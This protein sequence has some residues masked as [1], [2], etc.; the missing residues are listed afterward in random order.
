MSFENILLETAKQIGAEVVNNTLKTK[1]NTAV[2]AGKTTPVSIKNVTSENSKNTAVESQKNLEKENFLQHE[3]K[4]NI[5]QNHSINMINAYG[6]N[7]RLG[8]MVLCAVLGLL[9]CLML[10][11]VCRGN[12]SGEVVGIISTISGIFGACLKDAYSFEFGSS[13]GSREKDERI[14]A[15]I[16]EHLKQ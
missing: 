12:L 5:E 10:L 1:E 15:T 6:R 11:T 2:H 9:V 13:R 4:K 16:L 3:I 8:V 7:K 14:S